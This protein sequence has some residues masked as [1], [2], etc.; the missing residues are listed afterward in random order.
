MP[1]S[2]LDARLE[3]ALH[4]IRS[5]V[6]A[7]I[8][9]DHAH[10]PIRL[11]REGRVG[12]CVVVELNPGPLALAQRKVARARLEDRIEVRAGN[13]FAPLRPGEVD[14]ASMTGM[15]AGTMV[16]ILDRAGER[17]PPTL[18]LQP[19]DSPR[20]LRVW[21]REHGYHLTAE[22]LIAGYW[23]YPVL[24][25]DRAGGTDPAYA[26]LPLNAALRYGPHLLREGSG[27]LR[28][29]VEADIARLVPLAA[30]GRT[31]QMELEA[32]RDALTV[33]EGQ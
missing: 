12:R 13:G 31:A 30:P 21:A 15:G 2:T 19:N 3:A 6:H 7:D 1:T 16:G 33:L 9:S 18:V 28:E 24:R 27:L 26:S 5:E 8:G 20:P 25:L 23:P 14:S 29:Q 4:L 11:I 17:R 10:L 32:A 22:R